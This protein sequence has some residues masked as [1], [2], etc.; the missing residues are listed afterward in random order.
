MAQATREGERKNKAALDNERQ[1]GVLAWINEPTNEGIDRHCHKS[2]PPPHIQ[3]SVH[4]LCAALRL[5]HPIPPAATHSIHSHKD[6]KTVIINQ[7]RQAHALT[8]EGWLPIKMHKMSFLRCMSVSVHWVSVCSLEPPLCGGHLGRIVCRG[9]H[10]IAALVH[11]SSLDHLTWSR[12]C[13]SRAPP[14][15]VSPSLLPLSWC[16]SSS[17]MASTPFSMGSCSRPA[18]STSISSFASRCW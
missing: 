3:P 2:I 15:P 8:H 13:L 18:G 17:S 16:P 5:P 1:A 4:L 9:H 7:C 10:R 14:P 11:L 6:T 12:W